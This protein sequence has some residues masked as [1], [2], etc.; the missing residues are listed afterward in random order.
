MKTI[1]FMAATVLATNWATAQTDNKD[2]QAVRS[3]F[4]TLEK[5]WNSK[6]GETFSSVFAD[7]HDYIVVNGFYF[8][9]FTQ[10]R[11][12]AAHQSLFDGRYKTYDIKLKVDKVSFIR[13]DLAQAIVLGAGAERT[14][15]TPADPN[16]IMT[17]LVE[18]KDGQWKII[19]FHNHNL[20][21]FN[22]QAN[23]PF[24]LN[25]MYASW[26]KN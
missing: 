22:D 25:V 24:P 23:A 9:N 7:V 21:S 13:P 19:S 6:S 14:A 4:A 20:E 10:Q 1:I 3:I 15:G 26:Y 8:P 2:E 16:I 5:G 18:K 11:N 12:A 17:T